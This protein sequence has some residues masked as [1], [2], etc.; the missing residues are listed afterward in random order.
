MTSST[1]DPEDVLHDLIRPKKGDSI[2]RRKFL[3][4]KPDLETWLLCDTCGNHQAMCPCAWRVDMRLGDRDLLIAY[5][6]PKYLNLS[7]RRRRFVKGT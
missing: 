5:C 3:T 7:H 1:V 2:A 4:I 6:V